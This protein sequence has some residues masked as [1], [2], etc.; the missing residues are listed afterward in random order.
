MVVAHEFTALGSWTSS[1]HA[2]RGCEFDAGFGVEA[3]SAWMERHNP[4]QRS[5]AGERTSGCR[6]NLGFWIAGRQDRLGYRVGCINRKILVSHHEIPG[7]NASD[8]G[9][10]AFVGCRRRR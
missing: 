6:M 4:V 3:C 2:L 7:R 1:A 5:I 9:R 10:L 8:R